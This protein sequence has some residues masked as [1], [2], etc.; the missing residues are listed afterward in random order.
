MWGGGDYRCLAGGGLTQGFGS[1]NPGS[2]S[3][4]RVAPSRVLHLASLLPPWMVGRVSCAGLR[5]HSQPE[6][7][8]KKLRLALKAFLSKFSPFLS[9]WNHSHSPQRSLLSAGSSSLPVPLSLRFPGYSPHPLLPPITSLVVWGVASLAKSSDSNCGTFVR[10]CPGQ[11]HW[12]FILAAPTFFL[13]VI[14]PPDNHIL[15][16]AK[17]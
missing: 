6:S 5:L 13:S 15:T 14:L 12:R 7:L 4:E 11:L 17:Y 9:G 3:R 10:P 1:P 16:A 8:I 2:L